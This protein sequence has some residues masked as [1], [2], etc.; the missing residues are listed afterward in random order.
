[1]KPSDARHDLEVRAAQALKAVLQEISTVKVKEIRQESPDGR[2]DS[3]LTAYVDVFGHHHQL[4]CEIQTDGQPSQLRSAFEQMRATP[5]WRRGDATP[6][7]IAPY[8]SPEAQEIC[9]QNEA[10]FL[11]LEG[12]ARLAMGEVF[13]VKRSLP[14]RNN[15]HR[16][17]VKQE[18]PLSPASIAENLPTAATMHHARAHRADA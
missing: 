1:M 14:F 13:I 18:L 11:D 15:R 16:S 12:N 8:L 9:K 10:G 3:T 7:I 6:V 17:T 4:A 2:G 5:A